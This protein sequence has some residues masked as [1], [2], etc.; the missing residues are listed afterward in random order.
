M[1]LHRS[2]LRKSTAELQSISETLRHRRGG[3]GFIRKLCDHH[4]P[5]KTCQ[6]IEG[7][8]SK[9]DLRRQGSSAFMCGLAVQENSSYCPHHHA[10]CFVK[11]LT[12]DAQPPASDE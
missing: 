1:R 12:D 8:P 2:D 4:S 10:I 6:W 9:L 3:N 5:T 7:T 11:P